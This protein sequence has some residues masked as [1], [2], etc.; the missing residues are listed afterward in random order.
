MPGQRSPPRDRWRAELVVLDAARRV[1]RRPLRQLRPPPMASLCLRTD[2]FLR[3]VLYSGQYLLEQGQGYR[4][5]KQYEVIGIR[6]GYSN[7]AR[8]GLVTTDD[9]GGSIHLGLHCAERLWAR[10]VFD[11][12]FTVRC[13]SI[14]TEGEVSS[15]CAHVRLFPV[16]SEATP[17]PKNTNRPSTLVFNLPARE[18]VRAKLR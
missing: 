8:I 11:D 9:Q 1:C 14:D 4:V 12:A 6:A 15:R 13:P 3:V 17:M 10:D 7:T 5:R 16:S 18:S 2:R